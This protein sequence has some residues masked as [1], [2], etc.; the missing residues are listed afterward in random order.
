MCDILC[1]QEHHLSPQSSDFLRTIEN[2]FDATVVISDNRVSENNNLRRGGVAI[3]WRKCIG[4]AV[5]DVRLNLDTDRIVG[6]KIH[7]PGKLPTFIFSVYMPSTN[8]STNE[9]QQ[10]RH[11]RN[12]L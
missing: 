2:Q 3:L 5:S 12:H 10:Y 9:Y 4:Y 8:F 6:I 11:I 7:C 1:I